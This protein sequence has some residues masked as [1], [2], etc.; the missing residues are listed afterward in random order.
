MAVGPGQQGMDSLLYCIQQIGPRKGQPTRWLQH[1]RVEAAVGV[2]DPRADAKPASVGVVGS[3]LPRRRVNPGCNESLDASPLFCLVLFRFVAWHTHALGKTHQP[4]TTDAFS[5]QARA[6]V[7]SSRPG[8]LYPPPAGAV[9]WA[10]VRAVGCWVGHTNPKRPRGFS[11]TLRVGVCKATANR[12]NRQWTTSR[13][14]GQIRVS[15]PNRP[16]A[17]KKWPE[18]RKALGRALK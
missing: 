7:P 4:S 17:C 6:P 18:E 15:G 5:P 11:L 16:H 1:G 14:H 10:P 13:W 12:S 9:R 3:R 2:P 8:E